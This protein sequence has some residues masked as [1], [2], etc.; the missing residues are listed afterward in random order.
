MD[1]HAILVFVRVVRAG[2]FTQAAHELDLPKSSISRTVSHLEESLGVR[3]LQRTTR[4]LHLTEAGQ[5]YL[6]EAEPALQQLDEATRSVSRLGK[7]PRGT[8]R[9]T[10]PVDLG[11]LALGEIIARFVRKY[12]RIHI[13]LSLSAKHVDLVAEGF[14]LAVRAASRMHDSSLIARKVGSTSLGLYASADYLQRKGEPKVLSDL[15][16]HDC[17]LFRGKNGRSTWQLLGPHG[18]ESVEVKGSINVD[19]MLF[20][21][22]A[23][24]AGLGIGRLPPVEWGKSCASVTQPKRVLPLYSV[25]GAGLFVVTSS[26]RNLPTRV[27]L[28]RDTL[29]A[30]LSALDPVSNLTGRL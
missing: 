1:L 7:E 15:A 16:Q 28:F 24:Q 5:A 8:I 30:E 10:A 26:L 23:V 18:E 2:S 29:I 12:P 3:L 22:E 21:R 4:K 27:A 19:E 17:V 6:A 25:S 11:I 13:E 20:V 9:V 14:D